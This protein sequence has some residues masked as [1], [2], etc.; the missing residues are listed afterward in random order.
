MDMKYGLS[1]M[2]SFEVVL[3]MFEPEKEE[4]AK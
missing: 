4:A 3:R 1:P 2:R